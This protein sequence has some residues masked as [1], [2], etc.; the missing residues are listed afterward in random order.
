LCSSTSII[1][2]SK[3]SRR[4]TGGVDDWSQAAREAVL[5]EDPRCLKRQL[6][7]ALSVSLLF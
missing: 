5:L 1:L 6:I 4:L 2:L 3:K 7:A